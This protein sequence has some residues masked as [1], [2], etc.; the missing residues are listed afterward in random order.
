[1]IPEIGHFSLIIATG[2]AFLLAI[3]PLVGTR[4]NHAGMINSAKPLAIVMF[5]FMLVSFIV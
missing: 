1:M 4:I 3:Y 5:L 2:L